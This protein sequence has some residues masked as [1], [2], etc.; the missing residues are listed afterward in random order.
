[1]MLM[2]IIISSSH[3]VVQ[4]KLPIG[5]ALLL[6]E[7]NNCS[8]CSP[9]SVDPGCSFSQTYNYTSLALI[10][11]PKLWIPGTYLFCHADISFHI[12]LNLAPKRNKTFGYCR[13]DLGL[14]Q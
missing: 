13:L 7:I 14:R 3:S 8:L 5:T 2:R 12:D 10:V 6:S 4:L 1:M 9:T 11:L